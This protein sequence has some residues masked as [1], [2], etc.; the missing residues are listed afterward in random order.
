MR[1]RIEKRIQMQ[2]LMATV[3][4]GDLVLVDKIDRWSRDAEFSYSSIRKILEMGASFYAVGDALDPSTPD[5]DTALGFRILFAREEAKR[6]KL[7]LNGTQQILVDRGYYA[8]GLAP[9]GYQRQEDIRGPEHNVLVV[10]PD[11]AKV[12]REAF[13]MCIDGVALSDI[14]TRTGQHRDRIFHALK[15]RIYLGEMRNA[16]L[17]WMP[18]RHPAIVDA[19]TFIAAGEA[20]SGR[21]HGSRSTR[22]ADARTA[23]WWL[24]DLAR[25]GACS[26]KCGASYGQTHVYYM[27]T[28]R[29][30]AAYVRVDHAEASAAPLVEA[31]LVELGEALMREETAKPIDDAGRIEG[32]RD[33]LV[34]KRSRYVEAYSDGAMSREDFRAAIA[35]LDAER[36]KLDALA[37]EATPVTL[38]QR[39]EALKGVESI[40]R[41]WSAAR[42]RAKRELVGLIARSVSLRKDHDPVFGWMT[43][44]ELARRVDQ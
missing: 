4:K 37:S 35:R 34:A 15:N 12:V 20:L 31:R 7:R 18:A 32:K 26:A 6:I 41:A 43:A 10:D 9:W 19:A 27:C 29:C 13:R 44:E 3:Q 23:T 42:P 1:A 39:R 14:A 2:A 16:R 38:E 17:E 28:A 36:T 5:G 24:R 30:G 22:N 21:R 25:C 40:R 11:A 8:R 33:R